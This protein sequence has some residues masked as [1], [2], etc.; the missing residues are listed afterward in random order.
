[1]NITLLVNRDLPSC[2]AL[3]YILPFLSSHRVFVFFSSRVGRENK[4]ISASMKQLQF[5]EQELFNDVI[6]PL[7][8]SDKSR[9]RKSSL[10]SFSG[11]SMYCVTAPKELN[12]ING[13]GI[14]ALAST[15]PDLVV[16]IRYGVILQQEAINI[17]RFGVL[18]LHS[19]D[20]PKYR[21]VMASFRALLA[22]DSELKATLHYIDDNG[23][24][25]G[26]IIRK[27]TLTVDKKKSYLWHVLSI[28]ELGSRLVLD[29]VK[30]IDLGK[31]IKPGVS[32]E[33]LGV[34]QY[35]SFPLSEDIEKFEKLGFSLVQPEDVF[36]FVKK[37]MDE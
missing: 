35:Y 36:P 34:S 11:L 3:N 15:E 27:S 25:S 1:M 33:E 2:L 18:N 21:G 13:R 14:E 23:I 10:Q 6:F 4:V 28:Y 29:I 37:F 17:P 22:G 12:D 26:T 32:S 31:K 24:D 20:L 7:L 8:D 9:S 30:Q 16:S 5:F 19:G